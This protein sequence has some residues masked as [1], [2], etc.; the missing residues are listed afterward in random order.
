MLKSTY[1]QEHVFGNK[2]FLQNKEHG[3]VTSNIGQRAIS[4][5]TIQHFIKG[6]TFPACKNEVIGRALIK[7]T[8]NDIMAFFINR[9]PSRQFQSASDISFSVFVSSYMFGHD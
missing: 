8:P 2:P 9:L 5:S 6:L 7:K 4:S 1:R 3:S